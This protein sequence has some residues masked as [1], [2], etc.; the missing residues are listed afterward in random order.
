MEGIVDKSIEGLD[1]WGY[2]D[3]GS[4]YQSLGSSIVLLLFLS[5]TVISLK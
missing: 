3:W 2:E 1:G 5:C 4:W